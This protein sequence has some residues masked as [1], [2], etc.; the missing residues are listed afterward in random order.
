MKCGFCGTDNP[1]MVKRCINCRADLTTQRAELVNS[2][3]RRADV[4]ALLKEADSTGAGTQRG[5]VTAQTG[6]A[7]RTAW[8]DPLA[9]RAEFARASKRTNRQD[10]NEKAVW[11][12]NIR[13]SPVVLTSLLMM[14][15]G[16]ALQ[17]TAQLFAEG[18]A[19]YFFVVIATAL[20]LAALF[21]LRKF[22]PAFI[23]A[24]PLS[25]A[26]G[27]AILLNPD[28]AMGAWAVTTIEGFL[29]FA[30]LF[31]IV[32][33]MVRLCVLF[34]RLEK[35]WRRTFKF[36]RCVF[37]GLCLLQI[38]FMF[39]G[40]ATLDVQVDA[41]DPDFWLMLVYLIV[42]YVLAVVAEFF[43][44]LLLLLSMPAFRRLQKEK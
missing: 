3:V 30:A 7:G 43:A 33:G 1:G 37:L 22:A 20:M 35:H 18:G 9:R 6:R 16:L 8:I 5:N 28:R 11:M 17:R 38:C 12:A 4:A 36:M 23:L 27:V 39:A 19:L 29:Y 40:F 32:W 15:A 25:V 34:T 26:A 21:R 44:Y 24:M 31:M 41:E 2:G 13:M 14:Y 42:A 10:R